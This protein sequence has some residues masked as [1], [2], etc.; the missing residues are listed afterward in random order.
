[1]EKNKDIQD[2]INEIFEKE[3][4]NANTLDTIK[5]KASEFWAKNKKKIII[6]AGVTA[7][8][9]IVYGLCKAA[10]NGDSIGSI[11]NLD[12][13][14]RDDFDDGEMRRLLWEE[15]GLEAKYQKAC[16]LIE[17]VGKELDLKPDERFWFTGILQ[18]DNYSVEGT[19]E[20]GVGGW[21]EI[22]G[23]DISRPRDLA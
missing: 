18:G 6:G 21:F 9:L 14:P 10:S 4:E 1:M 5:A 13:R 15:R 17:N 20:P 3:T 16:E 12:I 11:E 2:E 19:E 22:D 7:A 23:S 8:A